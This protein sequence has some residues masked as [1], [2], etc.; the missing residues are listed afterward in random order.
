MQ[1]SITEKGSAREKEKDI[2]DDAHTLCK[3]YSLDENMNPPCKKKTWHL[4][5]LCSASKNRST[6]KKKSRKFLITD[7]GPSMV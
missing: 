4:R 6:A 3:V 2:N 7:Q 1:R 5:E